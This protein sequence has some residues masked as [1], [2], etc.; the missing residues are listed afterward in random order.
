MKRI[1]KLVLFLASVL[2]LL[3]GAA[4][5]GKRSHEITLVLVPRQE[6][7]V[8]LGLDIAGKYP[9]LLIS[10]RKSA[11]GK[12][13]LHGWAGSKWVRVT[14]ENYRKGEFFHHGPSAALI[15]E[16]EN[17]PAPE[18]L[19]PPADWCPAVYKISTTRLR[20]LLHLLGRFYDFSAREWKWFAR[21]YRLSL[22]EINPEGLNIHWYDKPLIHWLSHR[23][24]GNPSNDL[25][26]WIVLRGPASAAPA[27]EAP[28]TETPPTEK[29][30]G[31]TAPAPE[32]GEILSN[33]APAALILGAPD[34]PAE[35]AAEIVEPA[36]PAPPEAVGVV[37]ITPR[38]TLSGEKQPPVSQP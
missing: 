21:R 36:A 1:G 2:A 14:L 22:D 28:P 7:T 16:D 8:R 33:E 10:Y 11:D 19:V 18:E 38:E 5:A 31:G 35:E 34:V 15:I 9:T 32:G 26:F 27:P 25:D 13:S 3:P 20:P 4:F 23:P 6:T 12:I 17:D 30:D 37:E 29:V 24:A